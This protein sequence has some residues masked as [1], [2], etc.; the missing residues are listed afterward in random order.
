MMVMYSGSVLCFFFGAPSL[1]TG[2][3]QR[4]KKN[5]PV[6]GVEQGYGACRAAVGSD[7]GDDPMTV[8]HILILW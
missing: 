3:V 6:M 7:L 2:V 8:G 5:Q 1:L 4:D